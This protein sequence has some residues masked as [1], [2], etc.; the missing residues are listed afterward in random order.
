MACQNTLAIPSCL[1]SSPPSTNFA[2]EM[3]EAEERRQL[4][5]AEY[6]L[7]KVHDEIET[8]VAERTAELQ[9]SEARYRHLVDSSQGL[10]CTHDLEGVLLSVNPT[11]AQAFG[12][13]P[14][15]HNRKESSRDALYQATKVIR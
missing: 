11:T 6:A 3:Q 15:G 8:R 14:Q 9:V 12:A 7:R 10:I 1:P 4:R 5:Q 2:R 13:D